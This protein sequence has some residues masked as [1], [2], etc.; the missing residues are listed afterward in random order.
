MSK[1]NEP[2]IDLAVKTKVSVTQKIVVAFLMA[3]ALTGAYGIALGLTTVKINPR[4]P[5]PASA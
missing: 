1:E 3:G 2:D 4:R 5:A